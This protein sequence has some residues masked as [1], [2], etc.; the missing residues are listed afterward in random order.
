MLE[1]QPGGRFPSVPE[2]PYLIPIHKCVTPA[3]LEKRTD[4]HSNLGLPAQVPL[5]LGSHGRDLLLHR[6]WQTQAEER[7]R[8][9]NWWT[10]LAADYSVALAPDFSVWDD[11][12]RAEHLLEMKRTL[13]CMRNM[14]DAGL[15]AFPNVFWDPWSSDRD[16][17]RWRDWLE[18]NRGVAAMSINYQVPHSKPSTW[19][20]SFAKECEQLAS[21]RGRLSWSPKL[22]AVGIAQPSEVRQLAETGL[23]L[24]VANGRAYHEARSGKAL[25]ADGATVR[26]EMRPDADRCE[27]LWAN[28]ALLD[29]L[30]EEV[31]PPT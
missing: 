24:Y 20:A 28:L 26:T 5:V 9:G 30:Y 29:A 1:R 25:V 31:L 15:V 12:P 16:L 7:L 14:Q 13:V 19:E 10:D 11:A 21:L 4:A 3:R 6:I 2:R 8:G 23:E 22:I 18:A 17:T 27:L